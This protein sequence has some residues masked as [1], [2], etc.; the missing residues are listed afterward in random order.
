MRCTRSASSSTTLQT[1]T[2]GGAQSYAARSLSTRQ[3]CIVLDGC[4]GRVAEDEVGEQPASGA[5]EYVK[6]THG[7]I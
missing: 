1:P 2:S 6:W 4:N 3:Q 5:G 7:V